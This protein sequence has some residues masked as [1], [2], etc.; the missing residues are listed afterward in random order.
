MVLWNM[1]KDKIRSKRSD[2][3][4]VRMVIMNDK[5]LFGSENKI[6]RVQNYDYS[7]L[8][9]SSVVIYII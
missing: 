7:L 2:I 4:E 3:Y 8:R 1:V 5:C 6:D 9:D